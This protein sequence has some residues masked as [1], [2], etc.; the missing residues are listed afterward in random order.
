MRILH[1]AWEYPP[2][3]HGGL[4]RHV[5]ALATAQARLGHEVTVITRGPQ[6]PGGP[7]PD[8][9]TLV[10]IGDSVT[11]DLHDL[12]GWVAQ[13]ES[14]FTHAGVDLFGAWQPDVVHA[15]DWMVTH[16]GMA[17]RQASGAP[18]VA[19]VHA[20]EA[21]RHRG[22][23]SNALSTHIHC[24]EW[25]LA[26]TAEAVITCSTAMDLEVRTLFGV[27]PTTVIAN[28]ID[29][30]DWQPDPATAA[31]IRATVPDAAPLLAFTGRVEWEKG[32]QTLLEALTLLRMSHPAVVLL[33][34]GS[35]TYLPTLR[36]RA[37]EL[38]VEASVRFL[39]RV[40][41]EDLRAVV[42]AADLAVA[43][44]LY[45]P[46]GLIALEAA[47][48]GTPL[49]VADTG[50][51]AEFAAGGTIAGI[52]QPGNPANLAATLS[53]ELSD[54]PAARRRAQRAQGVLALRYD[55]EHLAAQTVAAY[56]RARTELGGPQDDERRL[57]ARTRHR[58]EQPRPT[59]APGRLLDT[60]Q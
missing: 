37:A 36:Q 26:N 10:R 32:V 9:V 41:D 4:G 48:L 29:L 22:W 56:A 5:H 11:P 39:G 50:G 49:V 2:V 46:F 12:L 60:D 34:A 6:G 25:L 42:V 43:P 31:R 19:T 35:G 53:Q 44:S 18:L 17:L 24:A 13:L 15:H 3:L 1:L 57:L 47:A 59:E 27:G 40:S 33:V 28:G 21:G 52:F 58:L 55:W 16:A 7:D 20:T 54:P 30:A 14:A 38:G 45:E 51:L 23:V 8:G